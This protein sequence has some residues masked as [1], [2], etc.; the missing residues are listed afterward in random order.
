[1]AL[2]CVALVVEL[3]LVKCLGGI[4]W[5]S[6]SMILFI[7]SSVSVGDFNRLGGI[8]GSG[9]FV[10]LFQGFPGGSDGKESVCNAGDMGSIPGS[11][12]SPKEGHGNP[13][14]YSCLE[15]SMDKGAWQATV[16]G[17]VKSQTRLSN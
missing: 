3:T 4:S 7:L 16:H 14:Q 12:R 5:F 9:D 8:L 1:M 10:E 11:G 17:L 13:L 6:F 15:N 2:L